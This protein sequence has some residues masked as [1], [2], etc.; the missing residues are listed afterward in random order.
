MAIETDNLIETNDRRYPLKRPSGHKVPV[1]RWTLKL[2]QGVTHIYTI[3]VGVQSHGANRN[4]VSQAEQSIQDWLDQDE[5]RPIAVDA[6][7]VTHGFD[8]I[9]SKVWVAYWTESDGFTAKLRRLDIPK[10]WTD[11]GD[12]RR[13]IG[14]WCE[15][16]VTPIDRLETN[17]ASLKHKPGLAQV[18]GGEFPAHDLTAYWGAGRDRIP[19]A[20]DDLFKPPQDADGPNEK[21]KGIGE[22]MTGTN[23]DNMCHI[24]KTSRHTDRSQPS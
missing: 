7:R 9:D 20:K 21:P 6:F 23:Y 3:Y 17:Y 12:D 16:F 22:R 4:H 11:L 13:S 10:I 8:V 2:P 24:R 5:G 15:H 14:I 1:P 19:A 18:P